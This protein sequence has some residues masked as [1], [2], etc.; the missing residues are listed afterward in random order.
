MKKKLYL[1]LALLLAAAVIVVGVLFFANTEPQ[2]QAADAPETP[3]IQLAEDLSV[4][5]DRVENAESYIIKVN[6]SDLISTENPSFSVMS[7]PGTY[8]I[9]VQAVNQAG[10]SDYSNEV[11]YQT[12]G[13]TVPESELFIV[14]GAPVVG[15]GQD[16]TFT[17]KIAEGCTQC[18]PVVEVNGQAVTPDAG[19]KYTAANVTE[20]LTVTVTG[21]ELNSYPVTLPAGTGYTLSGEPVAYYGKDYTFTLTLKEGYSKSQPVVKANNVELAPH[22]GSYV[23]PN[24]TKPQQ[25]TV[26]GVAINTYTVNLT[27]GRGY[28]ISP[29][30]IQKVSHGESVKFTVTADSPSYEIAVRADGKTLSADNGV[31]V[32]AG[33]TSD[34]QVTVSVAGL[35]ALTW[36]TKPSGSLRS[37]R[38][39]ARR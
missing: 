13:V 28:Q 7:V 30:G 35:S 27:T 1:L 8:K 24:V 11:S 5:W 26:S 6:G 10:K 37:R 39:P 9:Q 3:V 36:K 29:S 2:E 4:Y 21:V 23:I 17:L 12:L 15:Y 38:S 25:I 33:I 19:G 32:I 18:E 20:N 22:N 16:Y 14:L 34:V 31:Y